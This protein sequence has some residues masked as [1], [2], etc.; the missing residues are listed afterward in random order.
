MEI[1]SSDD[2]RII[3]KEKVGKNVVE[4]T[5]KNCPKIEKQSD[6]FWNDEDKDVWRLF[7]KK[8]GELG[9]YATYSDEG[10]GLS[11]IIEV[12]DDKYRV[13]EFTDGFV[14]FDGTYLYD[15]IGR[16]SCILDKVDY[17]Y[18]KDSDIIDLDEYLDKRD[19][20]ADMSIRNF[21]KDNNRLINKLKLSNIKRK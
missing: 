13:L 1:I 10:Y 16:N 18:T 5:L 15:N 19:N 20:K 2:K 4:Y 9:I 8:I 17:Y 14:L 6:S 7:S 21:I 11:K 12:S 3:V